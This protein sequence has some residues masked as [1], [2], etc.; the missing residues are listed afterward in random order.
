MP[1]YN[2]GVTRKVELYKRLKEN[3]LM[4]S[5]MDRKVAVKLL[6]SVVRLEQDIEHLHLQS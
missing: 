1:V 2:N 5:D 3:R 4:M 6:C